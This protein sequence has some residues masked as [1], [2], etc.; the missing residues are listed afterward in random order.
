ME[1]PVLE[2]LEFAQGP[3]F[4]MAFALM[5]LGIARWMLLTMSDAVAAYVSVPDRREFWQKVKR[6][7]QWSFV[8]SIVLQRRQPVSSG[9]FAYHVVLCFLSLIVRLGA[10]LVPAF[11][12]AHVYLWEQSLGVAWPAFPGRVADTLSVVTIVAGAL[13]FLGRLYS[14]AVRQ[15]EPAWS[16][17]KPLILIFPFATGF[18]AMHPLMSPFDYHFVML[19][20]VLGA[21]VVFVM[22]PFAR[23]MSCM[24]VRVTDVIPE[25]AWNVP[26]GAPERPSASQPSVTT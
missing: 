26:I 11:M 13:L 9:M 2:T 8:P 10:V 23:L 3:L 25:A 20:H 12:V 19:A 1:N 5:V 22:I 17:F 16:F 24:H 18:L 4:R 7:L 21:C 14:P 6:R 15:I